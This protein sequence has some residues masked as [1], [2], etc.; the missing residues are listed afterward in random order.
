MNDHL[1]QLQQALS[2]AA[3]REYRARA[4]NCG[5]RREATLPGE[6][7]STTHRT[8]V[9]SLRPSGTRSFSG[10]DPGAH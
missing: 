8:R 10:S 6:D 3:T 2:D 4:G 7:G 5:P 9:R 1:G